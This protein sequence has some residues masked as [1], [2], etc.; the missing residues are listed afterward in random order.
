MTS[1]PAKLYTLQKFEVAV[2]EARARIDE[3]NTALENNQE[4]AARRAEHKRLADDLAQ[5]QATVKDLELEIG[6]L[7]N[8]IEELN[9]LLYSG[10]I[11]NPK[12]LIDRQD[13]LESLQRHVKTLESRMLTAMTDAE[14]LKVKVGEAQ[15][16][17][18]AALTAQREA[19]ADL[20]AEREAL[21]D[22]IQNN[23]RERK[24]AMK[25]V[26]KDEYKRYRQLRKQKR[27]MAVALLNGATCGLC[28]V[29]QTTSAVEEVKKE[30]SIVHCSNCGRIL[31]S[32]A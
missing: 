29:A 22:Q 15:K 3:I 8:Q 26:S 7:N 17:L 19:H 2:D 28:G 18:D 5:T 4:V 30:K 31:V 21:E 32:I 1:L 9:D 11:K 24:E 10:K 14:R 16:A 20:M 12:E 27:G 13:K 25:D 6:G 23:L